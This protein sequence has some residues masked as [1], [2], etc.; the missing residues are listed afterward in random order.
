MTT[1]NGVE[2]RKDVQDHRDPIIICKQEEKIH[3][4][5]DEVSEL[6]G[7]AKALNLR[8]NGSLDKMAIHVEESA[9]WRRFVVGVA[10]SLVISLLGGA[11]ALFTLSYSLGEFTRQIKV[12]T[13]RLDVIETFHQRLNDEYQSGVQK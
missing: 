7:E 10:I 8:I 2:R 5:W 4:I 12:N 9:Y 6:R 13:G 11:A 1:W 3:Q